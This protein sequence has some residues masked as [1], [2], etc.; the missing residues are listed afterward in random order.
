MAEALHLF[1]R[2]QHPEPSL[3]ELTKL[4][5]QIEGAPPRTAREEHEPRQ[6]TLDLLGSEVVAELLARYAAGASANAVAL[7]FGVS[8]ASV[9]RLVRRNDVPVHDRRPNAETIAKAAALYREGLSVQRV[10]T[11]VGLSKSTVLRELKRAGVEMRPR[12][13]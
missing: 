6:T 3:D 12:R 2:P 8:P 9:M 5:K 11:A 10:A 13:S 1:A 4:V 7:Q